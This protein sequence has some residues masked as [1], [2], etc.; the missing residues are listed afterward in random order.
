MIKREV[1]PWDNVHRKEGFW[2]T[3]FYVGQRVFAF[4]KGY[5]LV[6]THTTP[7]E[8]DKLVCEWEAAKYVLGGSQV[9]FFYQVPLSE[10]NV[11]DLIP[12]IRRSYEHTLKWKGV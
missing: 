8:Q 12:L 1:Y 6:L 4:V 11:A 10:E 7:Q 3:E 5:L 9:G 2:G